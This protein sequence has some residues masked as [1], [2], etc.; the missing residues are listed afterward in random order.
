MH[1]APGLTFLPC[2]T[3]TTLLGHIPSGPCEGNQVARRFT[4]EQI[5]SMEAFCCCDLASQAFGLEQVL[6]GAEAVT[7][8]LG[9]LAVEL[10]QPS[11]FSIVCEGDLVVVFSEVAREV[12]LQAGIWLIREEGGQVQSHSHMI[13]PCGSAT[14]QNDAIMRHVELVAYDPLV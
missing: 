7:H 4:N 13:R 2:I 1:F 14:N 9:E 12:Q 11:P 3:S 10:I 5:P 6:K 8:A